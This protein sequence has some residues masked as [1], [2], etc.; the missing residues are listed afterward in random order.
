MT[1]IIGLGNPGR[2]YLDTRHNVGF[3]FVDCLAKKHN[4]KVKKLECRALTGI[5][6][7][8]GQ[9]VLIAKPQTFMNASGE[10]VRSLLEKYHCKESDI[11]VVYDDISLPV[12]RIRIRKKGSAGGHNGIKSVIYQTNSDQFA[13]LKI[14]VGGPEEDSLVD[15]VLGKFSKEETKKLVELVPIVC[16]ALETMITAGADTAMNR[17]NHVGAED[18]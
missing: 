9:E 16:E 7:I 10:S 12:G 18:E 13:R 14:G 3:E 2:K 11:I 4:I 5:G 1:I 6:R 8:E 15:Y 17:F